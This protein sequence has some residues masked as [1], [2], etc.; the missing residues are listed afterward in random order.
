MSRHIT[1]IIAALATW[2]GILACSSL[3]SSG[4]QLDIKMDQKAGGDQGPTPSK[5]TSG[6]GVGKPSATA[7]IKWQQFFQPKPNPE[8]RNK[9]TQELRG[10]VD[11]KDPQKLLAKAR[12]ESALGLAKQAETTLRQALRTD[13]KNKE[14]LLDL[15]QIFVSDRRSQETYEAL[16]AIREILAR[17]ESEDQGFLLRYRYVLAQ[18]MLLD[19]NT[20]KAHHLLTDL[21]RLAPDFAPAY[22]ALASSYLAIGKSEAARFI[23]KSAIDRCPPSADLFNLMGVAEVQ[24][25][26]SDVAKQY[27]Q[28]A[29]ALNP[30]HVG[31]LVNS[32]GLLVEEFE[33]ESAESL[34]RNAITLD[35]RSGES[36]LM[37][38]IIAKKQ[39]KITSAKQ[40]M[41]RALEIDP[42]NSLARYNLAVL[43]A[44]GFSKREEA[45][46]LF[47]E[48]L[49]T[50]SSSK[51]LR[52]ATQSYIED[53]ES[54]R[55][56]M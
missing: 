30:T 21:V 41:T 3:K 17:E 29:T 1:T 47:H 24:R 35:P 56:K 14:V 12:K 6:Y 9:L 10:W 49:Q 7:L 25:R 42:Q 8:E 50:E 48:V 5:S 43:L 26:N 23:L 45:I 11:D 16:G 32:A 37:L 44:E 40:E 18:I 31:A 34:L 39:G 28:K 52:Q 20:E 22:A 19:G 33:F 2:A 55:K 46:R 54:S 36:H 53:L 27:F 4:D 51:E 38:G 15:A 13:G